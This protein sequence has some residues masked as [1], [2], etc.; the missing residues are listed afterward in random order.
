K[1]SESGIKDKFGLLI[2]GAKRKAEEIEFNPPPSQVF[3]EGMTL[4]VMG[5]VDGIARA[6]KAF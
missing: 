5:E 1:I 3:T 2:L 6:K 4:I